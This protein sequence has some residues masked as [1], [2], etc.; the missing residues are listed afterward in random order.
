MVAK[1]IHEC[2]LP[3]QTHFMYSC[4]FA[5]FIILGIISVSKQLIYSRRYETELSSHLLL[6][7]GI[8]IFTGIS[9]NINVVFSR[10]HSNI[11][12]YIH[13]FVVKDGCIGM[14]GICF[15]NINSK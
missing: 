6:L 5:D 9:A 11:V 10:R 4:C 8:F 1:L 7:R 13:E 15:M 2:D 3:P 12:I 14:P